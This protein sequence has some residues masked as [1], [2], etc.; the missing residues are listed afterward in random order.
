M[1]QPEQ[2]QLEQEKQQALPSGKKKLPLSCSSYTAN[3]L[4]F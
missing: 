3:Q 1:Q 4:F 2:E